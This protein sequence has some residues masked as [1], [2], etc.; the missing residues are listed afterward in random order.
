[1]ISEKMLDALVTGGCLPQHFGGNLTQA[2]R[3]SFHDRRHDLAG[4]ACR[5]LICK[6]L[7]GDHWHSNTL[8]LG[9]PFYTY[10]VLVKP[11][12]RCSLFF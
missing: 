6:E 12:C 3:A 5:F 4:L 10:W 7:P 11:K 8:V 9:E 1:M 2:W